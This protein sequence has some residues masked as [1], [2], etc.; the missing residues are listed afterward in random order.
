VRRLRPV[1]VATLGFL[2]GCYTLRPLQGPLPEVGE[3]VAFDV[4]DAGRVALGGSMGP[5][6]ARVEG[7]LVEKGEGSYLVSVTAVQLVRGGQQVW[8][9]EQIRL[10]A[11]HL[12]TAYER[13]FSLGRSIAMG[14]IGIGGFTA[15]LI[16]RDLLASGS[17]TPN[18]PGDPDPDARRGRP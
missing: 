1:G 4:N 5:A 9:G 15:F 7:R 13:R 14:A 11:E 2:T 6:I 18:R 12:G 10:E 17:D 3:R 8:S 16:T